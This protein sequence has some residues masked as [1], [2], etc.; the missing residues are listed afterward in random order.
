MKLERFGNDQKLKKTLIIIGIVVLIAAIGFVLM[1]SY[2]LYKEEKTFNV[3]NGKIGDFSSA[4]I[5]LT[6]TVNGV[7]NSSPFPSNNTGYT[8]N[9][10]T[11]ENGATASWNSTS[12]GLT[13]IVSN[14]AKNLKCN[15]DFDANYA[16]YVVSGNSC[17][18]NGSTCNVSNNPIEIVYKPDGSTAIP[19]YVLK[20]DGETLTLITKNSI[21]NAKLGAVGGTGSV[22]WE[23]IM[24]TLEE[25]T[26][27][28]NFVNKQSYSINKSYFLGY[29]AVNKDGSYI[30]YPIFISGEAYSWQTLSRNNVN[31]R[32]ITPEESLGDI[33]NTTYNPTYDF[34]LPV[35]YSWLAGL[36]W[37][38]ALAS[39]KVNEYM[40]AEYF[41][42]SSYNAWY[43]NDSGYLILSNI[44]ADRPIHPV[45]EIS[46]SM[47]G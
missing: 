13:N 40:Y 16:Q 20:D 45:I 9:S 1:R 31:S 6:Y 12:W 8:V 36:G 39:D 25:A 3:I 24:N 43:L 2:A 15:V 32:L 34:D 7:L 21:G 33:S 42:A 22:Y 19:F 37:T 41:H 26:S 35:K 27:N 5:A 28:W 46:K 4:D 10:V 17:I 30:Y 44:N 18:Y 29:D 38:S 14:G 11:C 47:L 23:G